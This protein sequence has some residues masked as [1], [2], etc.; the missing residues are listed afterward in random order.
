MKDDR[1]RIV[2]L[3]LRLTPEEYQGLCD[4]MMSAGTTNREAFIRKM[5]LNGMIVKLDIPEIKEMISLLRYTGNNINQIAKRMNEKGRIYE[6]DIADIKTN[7]E[8]LIGKINSVIAKIVND[9][10]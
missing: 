6:D 8:Q 7:Q 2:C 1:K 5:A 4:R 9:L 3:K 10:Y